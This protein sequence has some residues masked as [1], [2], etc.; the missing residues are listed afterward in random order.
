[1]LERDVRV[2]AGVLA[3]GRAQCAPL[4]DPVGLV[5][6]EADVVAVEDDVAAEPVEQVGLVRRAD[7]PPR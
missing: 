6:G 5:A 2:L 3:D 1:M 7:N 4:V